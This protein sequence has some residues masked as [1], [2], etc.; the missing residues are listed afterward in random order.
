MNKSILSKVHHQE[1]DSYLVSLS[2]LIIGLLFI[3]IIIL[4]SFALKLKIAEA[5]SAIA[6]KEHVQQT[7]ELIIIREYTK[8]VT[9]N[10]TKDRERRNKMLKE[11]KQLLEQE[12]IKVEL[13]L[14]QGIMHLPESLLFKRGE[15]RFGENGIRA[16]NILANTLTRIIPCYLIYYGSRYQCSEVSPIDIDTVLIEG[17]TDNLPFDNW[18]LSYDRAKNTYTRLLESNQIL[19]T[20]KNSRHEDLFSLSAYADSRPV[21]SNA[22]EEGRQNNRRIDLRFLL[23]APGENE[24]EQVRKTINKDY[25]DSDF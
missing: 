5:N 12:G 11:I 20:F 9:D 1:D 23:A 13:D 22:S 3:F 4:M 21:E 24:I 8:Q 7:E 14:K 15:W 17:H 18:K 16:I 10:L 25:N 6:K 2:D 19:K